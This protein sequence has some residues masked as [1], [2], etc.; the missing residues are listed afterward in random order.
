MTA[1][2]K[3]VEVLTRECA[4]FKRG[5]EREVVSLKEKQRV[6]ERKRTAMER[7]LGTVMVQNAGLRHTIRTQQEQLEWFRADIEGRE[8]S[9]QCMLCLR[10][11]NAEVLP[12]TLRCGHSCCEE[13]IGRIT[14]KHREDSF[15]VC[16]EC[17]R[18]HFVSAVAGFPTSI[19]MIPGYIPP[20]PPHLQL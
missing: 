5:Y 12:K 19:S 4:T 1:L 8:A 7:N 14:V 3:R 17:R 15:A 18:W 20:P 2:E 6:M 9:R 10:A 16:T 13:C 11:Y